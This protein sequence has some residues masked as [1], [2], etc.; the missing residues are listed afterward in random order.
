[1]QE[2]SLSYESFSETAEKVGIDINNR[3]NLQLLFPE[4]LVMLKRMQVIDDVYTDDIHL[5][6]NVDLLQ[7][8]KNQ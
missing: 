7:N 3:E 2:E 6:S 5:S 8:L 4:V 1:M